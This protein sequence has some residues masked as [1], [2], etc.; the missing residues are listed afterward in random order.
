MTGPIGHGKTTLAGALKKLEPSTT[1]LESSMI[2]AEVANA[3]QAKLGDIPDPYNVDQLNEWLKYLP[4]ILEKTVHLKPSFEK[5]KL[6][7]NTIEAHPIEFQKLILHIENMRRRPE[8]VKQIITKE[9]KETF[10]PI[11]QWLG[12]YLVKQ[13]GSGI[14]YDEIVRRVQAAGKLGCKLCLVGGLRF[15]TDAAILRAVG[16]H[17]VHVYRP[18]Y[19]QG[20]LMDPTERE[21]QNIKPDCVVMSNGSLEDVTA[22]AP[23][24]YEDLKKNTLK[25]TYQTCAV[26]T[27]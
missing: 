1:H 4:D 14:W 16:A 19:L 11:L 13:V 25:H 8:L 23:K 18:G 12:G 9:N 24:F 22:F 5:I 15:P 21:R 17:I 20:D 10:R 6:D 27:H 3:L 2:V 26:K 7:Q